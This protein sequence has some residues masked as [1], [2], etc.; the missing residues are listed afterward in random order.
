M[1]EVIINKTKINFIQAQNFDNARPT[2]LFIHGA[3]QSSSTWRFQKDRFSGSSKFNF[4]AIDLPGHGKSEGEGFRTIAEYKS[5]LIE[6]IE[7]LKLNRPILIGHSM[8]GG[9]AMLIA[10]QNPEIVNA[11]VLVATGAKLSVAQQTLIAAK[12]NYKEFCELASQR[13]FA[14]DSLEELK[15]E[16]RDGL[17][18]IRPEVSYGDLIACNEFNILNDLDKIAHPT[19]IISSDKDILTPIKYG[20]YLHQNIYGSEFHQIKGSGHF[21]MQEKSIEFNLLLQNFLSDII[22]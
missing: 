16:F 2:L 6:F 13:M 11:L 21:I 20:E 7:T 17:L 9:I 22:E 15:H 5:F 14:E 3:G 4:I 12:D 19:L 8:G 18:S 1:S 10:I